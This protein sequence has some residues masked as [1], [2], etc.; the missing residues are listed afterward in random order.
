MVICLFIAVFHRAKKAYRRWGFL[1]MEWYASC[2][3][4]VVISSRA[5]TNAR[6]SM[7]TT[8]DLET[9]KAIIDRKMNPRV[10]ASLVFVTVLHFTECFVFDRS[11]NRA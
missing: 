2:R 11:K 4:S 8:T 3:P 7:S 9:I 6:V 10:Y 1:E 5:S